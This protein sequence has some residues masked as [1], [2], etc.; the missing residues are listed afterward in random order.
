[1]GAGH[2]VAG[3]E[4]AR[5]IVARGDDAQVVDL[6]R[7][8][9][10]AGDRLRAT[11]RLLLDRAPWLY[12]A[13]MRW[14][15]RWPRALE[16]LTALLGRS[17][18]EAL[19][20]AVASAEPDVVVSTY[21]L[22]SQALGRLTAR[23]RVTVPVATVVTDAGAHP[24]WVSPSVGRHIAPLALTAQALQELGAPHAVAA[25]PLLRPPVLQPPP[26]AEARR[27][28]GLPEQQ[29][30]LVSAGSWAAGAVRRTVHLLRAPGRLV[31]VLCGSDHRLRAALTHR[32]GV[33]AVA[34]TSELPRYLAAADVVVDNAGGLTCWEAIAARRPVVLFDVL[35]GHGRLNAE[36]LSAA[37][38]V[39]RADTVSELR[40]A[41]DDPGAA[42]ELPREWAGPPVEEYV[43]AMAARRQ[44]ADVGG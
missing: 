24:Y 13:S 18:E 38:L 5:R 40:A 33:R 43:L 42:P 41:V 31:A 16:N 44:G 14:W 6:L 10:A 23:G 20:G 15:A 17:A 29:I 32:S 35:P 27:R 34:W 3:R 37:A 9:G 19:A 30:V 28:L 1:M 25:A 39:R 26:A 7:V 12:D 21:N 36:A 11:Y 8:A 22:A 4:L 2:T